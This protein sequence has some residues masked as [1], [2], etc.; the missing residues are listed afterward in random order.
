MSLRR[1]PSLKEHFL[2]FSTCVIP[3]HIWS[4]V[5][6]LREFPGLMISMSVWDIIGFVAYAQVFALFESVVVYALLLL[7]SM[8]LPAR[9]FRDKYVSQGSILVLS[10]SVWFVPFHYQYKL[11]DL[12]QIWYVIFIGLWLFS[13]IGIVLVSSLLI[14]Q[15]QNFNQWLMDFTEQLT[16]LSTL[17]LVT[18]LAGILIVLV[19]N[20]G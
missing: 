19:R 9:V 16:V 4:I 7:V 2:L 3:I 14:R 8:L 13:F 17:Y 15:K 10:A 11:F 18:D 5:Q 12:N 1:C 20:I 6:T